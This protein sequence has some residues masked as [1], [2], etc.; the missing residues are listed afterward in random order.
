[1]EIVTPK[2]SQHGIDLYIKISLAK[3]IKKYPLNITS[4]P[5]ISSYHYE[6]CV[7]YL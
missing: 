1:M 6:E 2:D 4:V 3:K 5:L 7:S